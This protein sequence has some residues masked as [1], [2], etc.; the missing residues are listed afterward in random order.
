MTNDRPELSP[1]QPSALSSLDAKKNQIA[2]HF[3][4]LLLGLSFATQLTRDTAPSMSTSLPIGRNI[5][6][7]DRTLTSEKMSTMFP[8]RISEIIIEGRRTKFIFS[9]DV[10]SQPEEG[11]PQNG[12]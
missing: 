6:P 5:S 3:R 11:E 8:F 2:R 12:K 4:R 1:Q 10:S 9:N 7:A